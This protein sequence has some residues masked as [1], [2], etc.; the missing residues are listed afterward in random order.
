[1]IRLEKLTKAGLSLMAASLISACGG[2]GGGGGDDVSGV[3]ISGKLIVPSFVVTDSDV[4]DVESVPIPNHPR[5]SAQVVPNP[6]NI[7]GYVNQRLQGASGNSFS[8][9]DTDDYFLIDMQAGQTLLLNIA[10]QSSGADL[11]LFLYDINGLLVDASV[12]ETQ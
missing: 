6:V 9:G 8:T 5:T 11:D 4:N 2:G 7:G 1:M 12:G 10:D 3:N